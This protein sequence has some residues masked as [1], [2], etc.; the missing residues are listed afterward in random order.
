MNNNW[1]SSPSLLNQW[2]HSTNT[3][4]RN[5]PKKS[6]RKTII[7]FIYFVIVNIFD[8]LFP[9]CVCVCVYV[10]FSFPLSPYI[11]HQL[12]NLCLLILINQYRTTWKKHT[13]HSYI[14]SF[15]SFFCNYHLFLLSKFFNIFFHCHNHGIY[16]FK[17]SS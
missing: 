9:G 10:Y 2:S 15:V 16:R 1:L 7:Y 5:K 12:I 6:S 8:H 11:F 3:R 14:Y 13:H 17:F 4:C